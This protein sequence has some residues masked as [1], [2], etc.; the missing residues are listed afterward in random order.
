MA[1]FYNCSKLKL[2]EWAQL[3]LQKPV[4]PAGGRAW[5][6]QSHGALEPLLLS[7]HV[8]LWMLL[9]RQPT[10]SV[11]A[12]GAPGRSAARVLRKG[13]EVIWDGGHQQ[14]ENCGSNSHWWGESRGYSALPSPLWLA[15]VATRWFPLQRQANVG[16]I[17][18]REENSPDTKSHSTLEGPCQ[19]VCCGPVSRGIFLSR[20]IISESKMPWW[21]EMKGETQCVQFMLECEGPGLYYMKKGRMAY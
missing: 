17:C 16:G 1:D 3:V 14:M 8:S 4:T 7:S 5:D 15:P 18:L 10:H 19:N 20:V 21:N 13:I 11:P 6:S 2:H 12:A 9:A